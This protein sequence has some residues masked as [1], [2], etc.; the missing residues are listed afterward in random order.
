MNW[1]VKIAA[2]KMLSAI[3]GGA[4][5]Y[6]LSQEKITRSL[7]PSRNRVEQKIN[8]GIQYLDALEK[9]GAAQ[10]LIGGTHLDFG[11][12][13]H[14][15]IPL[16]YYSLGCKRQFLFDTVPVLDA[17]MLDATIRTFLEIVNDPSWPH[18][19]RIQ[20]LPECKPG[21][22]LAE[23]L[24]AMGMSYVSPY[25]SQF[26]KMV[27]NI[28]IVTSTQVLLH[29]DREPLRHCFAQ[30]QRSLKPG[31]KFLATVYLT[32]LYAHLGGVSQYNHF[33]Y[34]PWVWK[35]VMCSS[36]MSFNRF[37]ARDY[38]TLLEGTGFRMEHFEIEEPTVAD[39]DE[40]RKISVHPSFARY[41]P[42]EL[43]AKH[44]FFVAARP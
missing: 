16:L 35:N 38:R 29:I 5:L 22:P 27:E 31:G 17:Q 10:R 15:T 37:K 28:D 14:P 44:L 26:V 39:L 12:G 6:R 13:W 20:R 43:G 33:R 21:R 7:V 41:S 18:R 36:F 2:Y 9:I 19:A 34:S 30:I 23:H 4:R 11:S 32:D 1:L 24:Q 3:P 8:V 42:E 40:L 25:E